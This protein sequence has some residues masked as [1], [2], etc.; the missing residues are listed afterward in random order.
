M[1]YANPMAEHSGP[2]PRTPRAE[3]RR[4]LLDEAA[5]VFAERGYDDA[6]IDDIAHAAGFTKGAVYSNFGGKQGL[7]AAIL[8][9]G[10]EAEL[11]DVMA[12]IADGAERGPVLDRVARTV[13][14]RIVDDTGRA[15]LGLEFAARAG[16]D[17]RTRE[18]LAPLRRAQRDA[19]SRSIGEVAERTG[20]R[21]SVDP[22]LAALI[23][24]C[25]TNGLTNE[26][27]ADPEAISP[28]LVERALTTVLTLLLPPD[29]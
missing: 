22:D 28:E 24:H 14:R 23:L 11:K 19:A 4:R 18:V 7:F 26:R 10:A 1:Q 16:R 5:R 29:A 27:V 3:V 20:A 17:E 8:D 21:P 6:R 9:A 25:L 12:G 13:A 2:I 15:Q